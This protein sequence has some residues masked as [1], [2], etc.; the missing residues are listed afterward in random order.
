MH[1]VDNAVIMAA[2]TSSRFAPVSYETHKA[3]ITVK[4]EVLIER[5]I[6]QLIEAGIEKI[7][8]VTGYKAQ[9]FA[10]LPEKFPQVELRHNAQYLTRNNNSS[11]YAVRDVLGNSYICSADNYFSKNPFESQV[12]GAYYAAL[13]APGDTKEWCMTAD[14]TGRITNVTVGG[15]NA[16]YMLGHVFWDREFTRTFLEI[17]EWEYFQPETADLLWESIFLHNIDKF[18]MVIRKYPDGVIYE[19]D[20]LDE[21]RQFDT[22]YVNNTRS[23]IIQGI[24]K[25]LGVEEKD[26]TGAAVFKNH[27]NEAAGFCFCADGKKYRYTYETQELTEAL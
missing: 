21:L 4:G 3:M 19:F 5:Q 13:Y 16:W 25:K 20:T 7:Y 17:L 23:G 6:R 14:E 12:D 24:A 10:Y 8:V 9:Q 1:K 2:G 15:S 27:T 11:I 22:A 26:I 18:H